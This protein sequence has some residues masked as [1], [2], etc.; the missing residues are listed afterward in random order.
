MSWAWCQRR[1]MQATAQ[2]GRLTAN[3]RIKLMK[4][5][6]TQRWNSLALWIGIG[7]ALGA[8]LGAALDNFAIGIA[9]G[10][11]IG[12]TLGVA[13]TEQRDDADPP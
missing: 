3:R 5:T 10:T 6:S 8:G 1:V 2:G 7:L 9:I 4:P 12:V 13:F 11:S